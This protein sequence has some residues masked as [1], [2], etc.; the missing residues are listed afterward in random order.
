MKIHIKLW[1]FSLSYMKVH[2]RQQQQK[3]DSGRRE[4]RRHMTTTEMRTADDVKQPLSH[5][6]FTYYSQYAT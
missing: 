4:R 2:R 3:M 6:N 1:L 5:T